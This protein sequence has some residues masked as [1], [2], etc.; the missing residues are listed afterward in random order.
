MPLGCLAGN[1]KQAV[2]SYKEFINLELKGGHQEDLYEVKEQR[3][4][5]EDGFVERIEKRIAKGKRI[6]HPVH[7]DMDVLVEE[8]SRRFR[9]PVGRIMDRTRNREGALCRS[10]AAYVAME[11]G[12]VPQSETARYFKR[13][14][15]SISAGLKKIVER[16]ENDAELAVRVGRILKSVRRVQRRKYRI[17]EV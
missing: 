6:D 1:R 4:L 11:A 8:I 15:V 9:V 7:V 2:S 16:L 3:Y 17:S 13:D 10:V 5:G 14:P 12:G